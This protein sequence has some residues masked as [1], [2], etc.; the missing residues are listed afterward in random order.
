MSE[1]EKDFNETSKFSGLKDIFEY[2]WYKILQ[3]GKDAS[4]VEI[5]N[6]YKKLARE[7]HPDKTNDPELIKKFYLLNDGYQIL[8]DREIRAYYDWEYGNESKSS[9]LLAF[10]FYIEDPSFR[11]NTYI[12]DLL[13]GTISVGIIVEDTWESVKNSLLT[14]E[15]KLDFNKK[16]NI[17]AILEITQEQLESGF[18]L[19]SPLYKYKTCGVCRGKGLLGSDALESDICYN[20]KGYGIE[21]EKTF[22]Y[23]VVPVNHPIDKIVKISGR[24]NSTP[25]KI[26][27]LI[28]ELKL[29]KNSRKA[30]KN[31]KKQ[32]KTFNKAEKKN[33]F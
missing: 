19:A 5:K 17:K 10:Q 14:S 2:D 28:I 20:C 7:W 29:V 6:Q 1:K 21:N 30:S 31:A 15:E 32:L 13:G 4:E 12:D 23:I 9:K 24:G 22:V 27:D 33:L 8:G 26:G 18:R 11:F 16:C 25:L 3:V